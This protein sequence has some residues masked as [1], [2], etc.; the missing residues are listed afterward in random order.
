MAGKDVSATFHSLHR[1]DVLDKWADRLHVGYMEDY[2]H[3]DDRIT[4]LGEL[5]SVPYGEHP[6]W[7]GFESPYHTESHLEMRA[8]VRQWCWDELHLTG[9]AEKCEGDGSKVPDEIFHKMGQEGILAARLGPGEHLTETWASKVAKDPSGAK[10]FG[11]PVGEFDYFH[12]QI[13]H[14]E[15]ARMGCG[16]FI[17][18]CGDGHCIGAPPVKQFGPEWMQDEVLAPVLAGEKRICLAISEPQAGSDVANIVTTARK[19]ADG[20]HYVVNGTK[21]WITGGHFA[22]YFVVCVRTG[23]AGMGGISV[24]LLERGME[25]LRTKPIKTSYSASAGTSLV[26]MEDVMVPVNNL[27]GDENQGCE[28]YSGWAGRVWG[29]DIC[30]LTTTIESGGKAVPQLKLLL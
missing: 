1:Q 3:D 29:N 23:D 27:I 18:G 26:I 14:E 16:G 28:Y 21:K 10:V 4:S 19:T 11:V 17:A 9:I 2:D 15:F 30:E 6:A 20:K 8:A 13:L 12:E 7:Q 24:L 5:S 22:D 25:G